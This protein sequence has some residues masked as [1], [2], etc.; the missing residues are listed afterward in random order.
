MQSKGLTVGSS[1]P[2]TDLWPGFSEKVLNP[3]NKKYS[4]PSL[5]QKRGSLALG[6]GVMDFE[7][8][9]GGKN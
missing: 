9:G 4:W 5:M 7:G 8:G 3:L 1:I 2:G 6:S